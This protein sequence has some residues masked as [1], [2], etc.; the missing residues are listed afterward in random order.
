MSLRDLSTAEIRAAFDGDDYPATTATAWALKTI[1]VERE[2]DV[3]DVPDY[4][5]TTATRRMVI[6]PRRVTV[7]QVYESNL[8][9]G[10]VIEGRQVRRDGELAG[11]RQIL[12]GIS[13]KPWGYR[14]PPPNWLNDLL[15]A[16]GLEWTPDA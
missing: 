11:A 8:V 9:R 12:A 5:D 16:E 6:R 10:V 3:A 4:Q 15:A 13:R 7:H 2:Y 1:D 14:S